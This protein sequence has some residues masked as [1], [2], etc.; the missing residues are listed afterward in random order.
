LMCR[1]NGIPRVEIY[2]RVD[3][4]EQLF[5]RAIEAGAKS[6]SPVEPRDGGDRAGYVMD[7]DAHVLAFAGSDE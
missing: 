1:A 4:P 3:D 6:V 7:L 5:R 2:F